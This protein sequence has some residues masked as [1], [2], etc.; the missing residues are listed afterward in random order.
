[1]DIGANQKGIPG[2]GRTM[3]ISIIWFVVETSGQT[4]VDRHCIR[5]MEI[6]PLRALIGNLTMLVLCQAIVE[7]SCVVPRERTT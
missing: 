2:S 6:N 4:L 5:I 3:T 1:M 7:M